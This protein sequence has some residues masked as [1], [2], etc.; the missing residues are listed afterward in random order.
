MNVEKNE[1]LRVCPKNCSLAISFLQFKKKFEEI[2]VLESIFGNDWVCVDQF[3]RVFNV[4]VS[5]EQAIVL[6]VL[7]CSQTK[8]SIKTIS[9]YYFGFNG[10]RWSSLMITRRTAHL[11]IELSNKFFFN[12]SLKNPMTNELIC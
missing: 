5:D 11:F 6:Q 1:S 7:I 2:E 3:S 8:V 10:L 4:T 12:F 9:V